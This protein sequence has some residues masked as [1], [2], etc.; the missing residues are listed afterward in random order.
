VSTRLT[1][2]AVAGGLQFTSIGLGGAYSCGMTAAAA[3]YCWGSNYYGQLG[4]GS[5]VDRQTPIKVAMP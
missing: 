5:Y 2:V 3:I 1:P 4:D